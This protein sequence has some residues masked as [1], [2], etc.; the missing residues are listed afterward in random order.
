MPSILTE[1]RKLVKRIASGEATVAEQRKEASLMRKAA[2]RA[3]LAKL[4]PDELDRMRRMEERSKG[5]FTRQIGALVLRTGISPLEFLIRE[6]RDPSNDKALRV[7]CAVDALPYVHAKLPS[8][9]KVDAP[10]GSTI[11][12]VH[13][14][15]TQ[16]SALTDAE[17]EQLSLLAEK[18]TPAIDVTGVEVP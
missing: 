14:Q 9:M 17:L 4:D 16:L 7:K 18:L 12:F 8:E 1:H 13:V 6:M 15:Q 10:P 11:N 3:A 2:Q 5:H